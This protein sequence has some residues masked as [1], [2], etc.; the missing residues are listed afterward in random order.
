MTSESNNESDVNNTQESSSELDNNIDTLPVEEDREQ[1]DI[2]QTMDAN[3]C[4]I[5][6]RRLTFYDNNVCNSMLCTLI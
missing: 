6:Q 3:I 4:T 5:R 2:V 1:S